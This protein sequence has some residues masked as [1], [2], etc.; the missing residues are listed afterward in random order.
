MLN[1][2]LTKSSR[3]F[4]RLSSQEAQALD[5]VLNKAVHA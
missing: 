3:L 2:S 1:S 4:E 5:G